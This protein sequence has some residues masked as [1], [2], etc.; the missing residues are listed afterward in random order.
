M[1]DPR[2]T[3]LAE[4]LCSHSTELSSDD[5]V[6]IHAT[7]IP[8]ECV[9]EV[10]RVAQSKGAKVAVRLES[11]VVKRQLLHGMTAQNADLIAD[12]ELH[13][14]KNMTAYISMRGGDNS[15]ELADVPGDK[16]TLWQKHYATPVVFGQRVPHTKWVALRW[17]SPSMAQMANAS[18]QAFEDFYFNVCTIDY[19]KMQEAAKPLV[20]LMEKTDIVQ[21]KGPGT[22]LT[23][24]IK[25]IGA[26]SCHGV[27][28]IPDGECFSCPVKDSVNGTVQYNTVSLYQGKDFKDIRFVVKDGKIVEATAGSLTDELNAILDTDEGARYFGEWSLGYNP[29][30]LH[31]MRD[32]LFDEKIAGSFHLTPGNAY[33]GP[34]GNGNTSAIHWDIVCIQRP[35]YGGGEVWFDG[36]LIRK[37]GIFVLPELEGLNPDQLG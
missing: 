17:P 14:M 27:R 33:T 34:G 3:K 28:N 6:L 23:F 19:S 11:N 24:S 22:D 4:L 30:V 9:A 7:D 10:V 5:S 29:S 36:V 32:T 15:A 18:T 1:L 20:A 35:E 31:P 13:E 37:D 12:N 21:L 16:N 8:D 26:V 25:D 2:V